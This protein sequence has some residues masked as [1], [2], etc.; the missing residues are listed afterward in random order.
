MLAMPLLLFQPPP[1]PGG[2][3]IQVGNK[4]E[5]ALLGFVQDLKQS[6][7]AF[8][9]EM[10]EEKLH[11]VIARWLVCFPCSHRHF[12]NYLDWNKC[13]W[14]RSVWNLEKSD[15]FKRKESPSKAWER[16]CMYVWLEKNEDVRIL[17][18]QMCHNI[19]CI[20]EWIMSDGYSGV[21]ASNIVRNNGTKSDSSLAMGS[22]VNT[23]IKSC[24]FPFHSLSRSCKY[25]KGDPAKSLTHLS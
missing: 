6:Y 5:C 17:I 14:R 24:Y 25:I 2:Q 16:I 13:W 18:Y 15:P 8:R 20:S 23:V 22:Q 3:C 1:A 10:P 19:S 11:K 21:L 4:T 9:E 12:D 7:E